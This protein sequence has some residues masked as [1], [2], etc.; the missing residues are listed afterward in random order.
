MKGYLMKKIVALTSLLIATCAYSSVRLDV[1]LDVNKKFYH[2]VI[3]AEEGDLTSMQCGNHVLVLGTCP[4][5]EEL[6]LIAYRLLKDGEVPNEDEPGA[7][8]VTTWG[9]EASCDIDDQGEHP[10]HIAITPYN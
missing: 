3:D 7:I 8:C 10:F 9:Q 4:L 5:E 6:V 2:Q 1:K